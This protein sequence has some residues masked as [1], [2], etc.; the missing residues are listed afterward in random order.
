MS[1]EF[2]RDTC[3]FF[4]VCLVYPSPPRQAIWNENKRWRVFSSYTQKNQIN[5]YLH[6]SCTAPRVEA[7]RSCTLLMLSLI[8]AGYSPH[9]VRSVFGLLDSGSQTW[10]HVA[11][12]PD[13]GLVMFSGAQ[14]TAGT[15]GSKVS[16]VT[17]CKSNT[18]K[19]SCSQQ[20]RH[21][22]LETTRVYSLT[23]SVKQGKL[24]AKHNCVKCV[25]I[26]N[27]NC[28]FNVLMGV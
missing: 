27:C 10:S 16:S 6:I 5:F 13:S 12:S 23:T 26:Y 19:M 24:P 17:D 3:E 14:S 2:W 22:I 20:I 25:R 28:M 8:M 15:S 18:E 4:V 7:M 9:S 1:Y 11:E 21:K